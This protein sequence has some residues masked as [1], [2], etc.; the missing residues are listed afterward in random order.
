[1][2]FGRRAHGVHG[3]VRCFY[4]ISRRRSYW[5]ERLPWLRVGVGVGAMTSDVAVS[6]N[7]KNNDNT[8]LMKVLELTS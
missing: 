8:D 7:H 4:A 1:V 6:Q 3:A 5:P 2:N